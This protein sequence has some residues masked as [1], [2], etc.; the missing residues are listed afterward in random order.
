MGVV[1]LVDTSRSRPVWT[2]HTNISKVSCDPAHNT[3][4]LGSRVRQVNW[5]GRGEANVRK[6]R[7]LSIERENRE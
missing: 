3:S 5:A 1:Y 7:Y 2:D 4:P 6:L